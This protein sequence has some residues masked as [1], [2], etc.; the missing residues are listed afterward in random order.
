MTILEHKGCVERLI[1]GQTKQVCSR[2]VGKTKSSRNK[3][4]FPSP[5]HKYFLLYNINKKEVYIEKVNSVF[6][7]RKSNFFKTLN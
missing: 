1:N 7:D 2:K 4:L 6:K 3:G 5:P